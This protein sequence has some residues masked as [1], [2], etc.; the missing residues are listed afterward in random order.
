MVTRVKKQE[1]VVEQD[2]NPDEYRMPIALSEWIAK[3]KDTIEQSQAK[4][5]YLTTEVARLKEDNQALRRS[6]KIME[7]RVMGVSR[8]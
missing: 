2:G 5:R 6:H 4:V 7:G 1:S 8:E 3:A